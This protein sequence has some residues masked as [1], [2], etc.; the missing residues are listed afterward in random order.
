MKSSSRILLYLLPLCFVIGGT[1]VSFNIIEKTDVYKN[2]KTVALN[3]MSFQTRLSNTVDEYG[4]DR[5]E[6][7]EKYEHYYER[8]NNAPVHYDE[9]VQWSLYIVAG[10]VASLLLMLFFFYRGPLLW[11]A[12]TLSLVA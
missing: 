11:Q 8:M 12:S 1:I 4:L 7:M 10:C 9:G 6:S 2:E 5:M 3:E